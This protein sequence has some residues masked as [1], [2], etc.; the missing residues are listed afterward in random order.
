MTRALAAVPDLGERSGWERLLLATVRPEFRVE[1]F[2]APRGSPLLG[3]G[4]AV[5]GCTGYGYHRPWGRATGRALCALHGLRWRAEG[6]PEIDE[7]VAHAK[8]LRALRP[9]R[10]CSVA[11]CRRSTKSWG[12]CGGH[13]LRREGASEVGDG[14]CRVEGCEFPTVPGR[15]LC[16]THQDRY[17]ARNDIRAHKGIEPPAWRPISGLLGSS[18]SV[19]L[20]PTCCGRS[21]GRCGLSCSICS[22][23]RPTLVGSSI[24]AGS[25]ISSRCCPVIRRRR[26]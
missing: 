6:R 18:G 20:A 4:C 9:L 1:V 23:T 22:S 17:R 7:W 14:V 10:S 5:A 19:L 25:T 13:R 21:A 16:D 15:L 24:R 12:R 11:G 3:S 2:V 26:Y 8:P